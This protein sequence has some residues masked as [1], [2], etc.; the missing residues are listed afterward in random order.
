MRLVPGRRL[1]LILDEAHVVK[2]WGET[3]F[4]KDYLSCGN[5]RAFVPQDVPFLACSATLTPDTRETIMQSLHMDPKQ[6]LLINRGNNRP[7][8]IWA[9]RH[10]TG[11]DAAIPEIRLSLP[12]FPHPFAVPLTIVFV[13]E[14][15]LGQHVYKYIQSITPPGLLDQVHF[16]H[17]LRSV[18]TKKQIVSECLTNSRGIYI[19]TEVAAMVSFQGSADG[20]NYVLSGL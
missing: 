5:L 9:I 19:C 17:A 18:R 14:R 6:Y 4:R 13:N 11:A 16:L 7:N 20:S 3:G 10:L 15:K 8:I 1:K 12:P 2:K